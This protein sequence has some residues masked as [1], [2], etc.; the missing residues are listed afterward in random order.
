LTVTHSGPR[1]N[2]NILVTGASNDP[3]GLTE[4]FVTGNQVEISVPAGMTGGLTL[5]GE[6]MAGSP[7][8]MSGAKVT[9]RRQR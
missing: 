6:E 5:N 4:G 7:A 3:R 1:F 8:G 9:L 2:G